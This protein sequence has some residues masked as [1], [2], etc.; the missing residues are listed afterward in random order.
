MDDIN[1]EQ[2]VR[3]T[4][5]HGKPK[6]ILYL[7]EDDW[8]LRE[9]LTDLLVSQGYYVL[10]FESASAYLDC[11]RD[12]VASC[13]VL[14]LVLPDIHGLDLQRHLAKEQSIPIIFITAYGD[15]PSSVRA[16]KE[17]AIEFLTKPVDPEELFAA[18][19]AGFAKDRRQREEAAELDVLLELLNQLTPREREI[20]PLL[21]DGLLNKQVGSMLGISEATV[22]VHRG[23]IMKKMKASSFANLVKIALQLDSRPIPTGDN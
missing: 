22:Q 21:V 7:V 13:L 2:V 3:S 14:D 8:R 11:I 20:L 6:N 23:Q 9:A 17:G 19:D 18:V 4:K 5:M 1:M 15:I 10:A 16:M 12:D